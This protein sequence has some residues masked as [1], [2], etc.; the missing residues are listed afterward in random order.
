MSFT[1]YQTVLLGS[2]T[3][4][5]SA[6]ISFTSLITSAYSSYIVTIRSMLPQTDNKK[7][8]LTASTDNGSTYISTTYG[9]GFTYTSSDA[10]N[11]SVWSNS[12]AQ[13]VIDDFI[14]NAANSSFN[15]D[16][17]LFN[18]AQAS[19]FPSLTWDQ[20]RLAS[21][22]Y[23]RILGTGGFTSSK[24]INALKFAMDSGNIVSG[25][26]SLYGVIE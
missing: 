2:Q 13:W 21:D 10:G 12:D 19:L 11:G 23:Y 4:S 20:I 5:N 17:Q 1:P 26:F 7:L 6:S 18:L 8:Y 14:G 24:N 22:A 16:I 3:A 9:W 15:C 25:T